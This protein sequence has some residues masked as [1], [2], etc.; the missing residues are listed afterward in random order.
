MATDLDI[1]HELFE[2]QQRTERRLLEAE[3]MGMRRAFVSARS[4][5]PGWPETKVSSPAWAPFA[6]QRK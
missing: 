5:P 2:R 4:V 1:L 6:D 3:K